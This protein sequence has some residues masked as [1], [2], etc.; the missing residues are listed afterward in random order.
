MTVAEFIRN[1]RISRVCEHLEKT[2][3]PLP[4]IASLTGFNDVYILC[5]TFKKLKGITPGK[6][7]SNQTKKGLEN[8]YE[9]LN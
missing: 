6:Y 8:H 1:E 3:L 4:E 7:R 2:N 5:K 9:K